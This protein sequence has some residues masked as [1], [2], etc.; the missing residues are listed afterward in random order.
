MG[1]RDLG[2]LAVRDLPGTAG[3]T[4]PFF[5]PDGQ[6][7]GFFAGTGELKKVALA[8]GNPVTLLTKV[9]GAQ[10]SFGVWTEDN[11]IIFGTT[12]SGLSR[13]SSEG[14]TATDLTTP[15]AP[16]ELF[17]SHP[18]LVPSGRAVLYWVAGTSGNRI[19]AV[20]LGSG[21]RR[22]VVEHGDAPVV[23][24]R[25][26][27]CRW[28]MPCDPIP[29]QRPAFH[30]GRREATVAFEATPNGYSEPQYDVLPD[31]RFV[32]I[33]GAVSPARGDRARAALVRRADAPRAQ[34]RPINM[35]NYRPIW[36]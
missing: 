11:T 14:G 31:G 8:G 15:D 25:A 5:S 36:R 27:R 16:G 6:W 4:L 18:A 35:V 22:R 13:V 28:W 33:G 30:C 29:R 24:G 1:V 12:G 19:D 17:H 10:W 2:T 3:A 32:M 34:A 9:D 7:V 23:L 20:T 26:R 21:E